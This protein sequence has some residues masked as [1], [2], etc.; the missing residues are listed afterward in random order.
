MATD[1]WEIGQNMSAD[2]F[3][4]EAQ[5]YM[6]N[7]FVAKNEVVGANRMAEVC[8]KMS[9]TY[10]Q[11]IKDQNEY[12]LEIDN[13]FED[14]AALESDLQAKIE[15]LKKEIESLLKKKSAGTITEEEEAELV[16]KTAEME[17][18][19][20]QFEEQ[21]GTK[22]NQISEIANKA[23]QD[24]HKSK[25]AIALDYGETAVEKGEALSQTKNK[26][27]SFWRKIFGGWNQQKKRD[28]GKKLLES[29]EA[30]LERVSTSS[31]IDD[32][33]M[34]RTTASEKNY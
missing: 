3:Y 16:S 22:N 18:L 15:A 30:L 24:G 29:G 28:A 31:D 19:Q 6:P 1:V 13:G 26:R 17:S 27:K 11:I 23:E 12:L 8:D 32:K 9:E 4:D 20:T 21:V 5:F 10:D 14:I 33:I 7:V 2:K 25:Q 34:K